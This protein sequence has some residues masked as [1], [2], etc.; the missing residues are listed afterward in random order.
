M[1]RLESTLKSPQRPHAP[2]KH[3][4]AHQAGS[5]PDSRFS[6]ALRL[7]DFDLGFA[8][9]FVLPFA[10]VPL[11]WTP[12]RRRQSLLAR[13]DLRLRTVPH[14]QTTSDGRFESSRRTGTAQQSRGVAGRSPAEGVG[15]D[16]E[17][18]AAGEGLPLPF[19]RL[20][21]RRAEAPTTG[22]SSSSEC[23]RRVRHQVRASAKARAS[24]EDMVRPSPCT[25]TPTSVASRLPAAGPAF[26]G[27][28]GDLMNIVDFS[29][30]RHVNSLP[31]NAARM[32][33]S[34]VNYFR[35]R[36]CER[37]LNELAWKPC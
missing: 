21:I 13:E 17:D 24:A 8:G 19:R 9:K 11:S 33:S 36:F 29:R 6:L 14:G 10:A 2:R 3:H 16:L 28:D 18:S 35:A 7:K 5:L 12:V 1:W 26:I 31:R 15:R 4:N 37:T 30:M 20:D 34:G 23:R 22:Y 32:E 25:V 27:S